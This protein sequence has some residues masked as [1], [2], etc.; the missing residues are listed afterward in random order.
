MTSQAA[1]YGFA[2]VVLGIVAILVVPLPPLVL[3]ALLAFN[4]LGSGGCCC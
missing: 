3:D 1:T 2:A 4:V